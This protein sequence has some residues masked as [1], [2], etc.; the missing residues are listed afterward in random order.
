M[1]P[2]EICNKA[3]SQIEISVFVEQDLVQ[4]HICEDCAT[5][6]R[7]DF[8]AL[9]HGTVPDFL[10]HVLAMDKSCKGEE[11]DGELACPECGMTA[12]EIEVTEQVGCSLCYT[13]FKDILAEKLP[14][15]RHRTVHVGKEVTDQP[16]ESILSLQKKLQAAVEREEYE[17]AAV[18][19]DR[20]AELENA[21]GKKANG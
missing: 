13:I 19:R 7:L 16:E 21:A 20:I 12:E 14:E 1:R 5:D 15:S 18:L 9:E 6:C 3:D 4:L 8:E 2:C 10:E 11:I 17:Q